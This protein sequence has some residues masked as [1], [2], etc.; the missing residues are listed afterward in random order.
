MLFCQRLLCGI[1]Y[2]CSARAKQRLVTCLY[3]AAITCCQGYHCCVYSGRLGHATI[4][5]LLNRTLAY[6]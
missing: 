6:R 5:A 2:S 4:K 1:V 3:Q